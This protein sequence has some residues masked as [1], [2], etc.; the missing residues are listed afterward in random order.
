MEQGSP[1]PA[2]QTQ[3]GSRSTEHDPSGE[4]ALDTAS[5]IRWTRMQHLKLLL[6]FTIVSIVLGTTIFFTLPHRSWLVGEDNVVENLSVLFYGLAFFV[7]VFRWTKSRQDNHQVG[8][9]PGVAALGMVG[10]LEELSYGQRIFELGVPRI[11]GVE[12]DALHDFANIAYEMLKD[13]Y[14]T[15]VALTATVSAGCVGLLGYFAM[16]YGS[17]TI[18][19]VKGSQPLLILTFLALLIVTAVV[20]DLEIIKFK[21]HVLKLYEEIF[22]MNAAFA[23]FL[24]SLV[25]NKSV[26]EK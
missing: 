2:G 9:L 6:L 13:S 11:A 18:S 26:Q 14:A 20:I 16:R 22:E 17:R 21:L 7:A 4:S 8:W 24:L 12:F 15:N 3:F 23:V 10:A 5:E 19:I 1:T 25:V